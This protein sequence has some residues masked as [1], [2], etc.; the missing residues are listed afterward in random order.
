[1]ILFGPPRYK[2][3]WSLFTAFVVEIGGVVS[4]ALENVSERVKA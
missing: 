2:S 1:M 4:T 3:T